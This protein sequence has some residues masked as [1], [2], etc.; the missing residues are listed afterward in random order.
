[1]EEQLNKSSH[2]GYLNEDANNS[3]SDEKEDEENLSSIGADNE[4]ELVLLDYNTDGHG[5]NNSQQQQQQQ[6]DDAEDDERVITRYYLRS[7]SPPANESRVEDDDRQFF[8]TRNRLGHANV[9]VS[10]NSAFMRVSPTDNDHSDSGESNSNNSQNQ[11]S[12][13]QQRQELPQAYPISLPQTATGIQVASC[14]AHT[15]IT[16]RTSNDNNDNNNPEQRKKRSW[17]LWLIVLPL[18]LLAVSITFIFLLSFPEPT[19]TSTNVTNISNTTITVANSTEEEIIIKQDTT[20]PSPSP[21]LQEEKQE[22]QKCFTNPLEIQRIETELYLNGHDSS[23]PRTYI[24][25]PNSFIDFFGVPPTALEFDHSMG[26][27]FPLII[28]RPNVSILC[29]SDGDIRNNCTLYGGFCNISLFP[30]S[31]LINYPV[32][33]T[34]ENTTISGFQLTGATQGKYTNSFSPLSNE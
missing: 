32:N 22:E 15:I 25:C 6:N 11:P 14:T 33:E 27:Y 30:R 18:I 24:I 21:S 3:D 19:N 10:H 23:I 16:Q 7:I 5:D 31:L 1:M 29:G 9:T 20:A 12:S 8:S 4:K 26:S 13:S 34:A 2:H 28:F 17:K